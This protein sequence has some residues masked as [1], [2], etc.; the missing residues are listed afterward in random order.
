MRRLFD[1]VEALEDGEPAVPGWQRDLLLEELEAFR[2]EPGQES[3]SP[4]EVL[5]R[6]RQRRKS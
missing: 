4:E 5:E 2:R 1:I 6:L 3:Y